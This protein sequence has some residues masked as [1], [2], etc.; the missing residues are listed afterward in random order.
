MVES[1]LLPPVP[2]TDMNSR[3][4]VNDSLTECVAKLDV[5]MRPWGFLFASDRVHF[6]H[7][8]L[9]AAGHYCRDTTRI[10]LSCRDTIDNIYYQHS[11]ITK[12]ASWCEIERF[13]IGHETLM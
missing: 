1:A 7:T 9:F 11:F 6:S 10:G 12:H 3:Q 5:I 8:G 4:A 13:T 2:S